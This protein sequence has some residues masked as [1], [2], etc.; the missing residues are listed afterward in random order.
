MKQKSGAD[1]M[2]GY[3]AGWLPHLKYSIPKEVF[4]YSTSMYSIALEGWRRGLTLS[5]INKNQNKAQTEFVLSNKERRYRFFGSRG[6][7]ISKEAINICT[8]KYLTKRVL[9]KSGIPV[10][11]G[12]RFHKNT[13]DE[14]IVEYVEEFGYPVVLKPHNGNG[15]EGVIVNIQD[16]PTLRQALV[17][18]RRKLKYP[19][20]LIE[21]Y[22]SSQ[23][24]QLYVIENKVIAA[25][26]RVPAFVIGDGKRS[27]NQLINRKNGQRRRNPSLYQ[28]LIDKKDKTLQNLIEEQGYSLED[29]PTRNEKIYLSVKSNITVGGETVDKTEELPKEIKNLAINAAKSV[30]NLSICAVELIV[31]KDSKQGYV[32]E[33]KTQPTIAGHL[34]PSE[35]TARDVPKE[36]ID[37]F[38]PES[39]SVERDTLHYFDVNPV[40]NAFHENYIQEY[41]LPKIPKD[42]NVTKRV[43][44][45]GLTNRME[46]IKSIRPRL[47]ELRVNG[48]F[49]YRSKSKLELVIVGPV[50]KLEKIDSILKTGNGLKEEA[51]SVMIR[52]WYRP[53]KIGFEIKN[54]NDINRKR[55]L[56]RKFSKRN[57]KSKDKTLET[58]N[59]L[60]KIIAT[61][62]KINIQ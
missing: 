41:T 55:K 59:P 53:V 9:K 50:K 52:D 18:L 24:Y 16:E 57:T 17:Y 42:N 27:I 21:R 5:F 13:D 54:I 49:K 25:F 33:L 44:I 40:F 8:D 14:A 45:E 61:I 56:Q 46:F 26:E 23:D 48:F 34:F 15:G 7:I 20:V 58:M 1:I 4:G 31:E 47:L 2:K 19:T 29:I 22:I 32:L 62:K 10:V 28:H 30:P 3:K 6:N 37:Y 12:E 39:V 11:E 35:G 38:F 43:L 36:L 60:D 51:F